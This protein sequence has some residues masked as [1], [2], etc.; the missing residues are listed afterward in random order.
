MEIRKIQVTGAGDTRII[1]LPKEWAERHTLSKGSNVI[2]KEL[3]SGELLIYPQNS[4]IE[5][6]RRIF[7]ILQTILYS[8]IWV[9]LP[10]GPQ[11]QTG[12]TRITMIQVV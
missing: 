2:I 10:S 7:T 9:C 12:R 5:H 6:Q 3:S 11:K 1:S 4:P 8:L